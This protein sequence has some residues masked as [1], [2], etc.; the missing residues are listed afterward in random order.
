MGVEFANIGAHNMGGAN[1]TFNNVTFTYASNSLYNGLQHSGN[2]VYNNCTFNGQVFLYGQSETFNNCTFNTTDAANYNVWTYGAKEVAFNNCTFNCAGKSVLIY[3]DQ[4]SVTNNVTVTK[5]QFIASQAVEGKAAIEMDSSISGAVSLTIDGETTAT[6]FAAG[7]VSGNSLWNNKKGNN[8]AKNNDITVVV[9][10]ETVLAPIFEAQIGDVQYRNLQDAINAVQNGETITV[11]RDIATNVVINEKDNV[12]VTIDGN[13]KT[14]NGTITVKALSSDSDRRITIKNINFVNTAD[15]AVDFISSAVTNH[16]PRITVEG[17]TFTGSG[18]ATDVALRLK[19]SKNVEIKNCTGT[20]LH[21]FLQNTSGWNLTIENVK[22]TDSKSGLALGTVQ[23]VT[24]KGCNIDVPGYG[25]RLDAGYN[26]NAVIESNTVEAF[27][28]VVVRNANKDSNIT[29]N[30]TNDMTATNGDNVWCVIGKDEYEE[31]VELEDIEAATGK[32]VVDLSESNLTYEGVY[33]NYA[34]A[35]IGE[36][37][38]ASLQ[39]AIEDAQ[40]GE[41]VILFADTDE[42]V[43][44]NVLNKE[45]S[46]VGEEDLFPVLTGGLDF[47][48]DNHSQDAGNITIKGIKF[49]GNGIK[50]DDMASVTIEGNIFENI[51]ASNAIYVAADEYTT[52]LAITNNIITNVAGAGINLRNPINATVTGNT[53]TNVTGNAMTFQNNGAIE[54]IAGEIVIKGNVLT[55]W[56]YGKTEGRAIRLALGN[57][58]DNVIIEENAMIAA[59]APE[60]FVKISGTSNAEISVDKNYWNG[61]APTAAHFL[62]EGVQIHNYYASYDEANRRLQDLVTIAGETLEIFY[63]AAGVETTKEQAAYSLSFAV[64]DYDNKEASVKIGSKKPTTKDRIEIVTPATVAFEGV[65]YNVTSLANNAFNGVR[66]IEELIISEGVKSLGSKALANMYE[67]VDVVLPSTL[68]SVGDQC[69]YGYGN[70]H[71]IKT[72]TCLAV[73]PPTAS[74]HWQTASFQTWVAEN[75]ILFVAGDAKVYKKAAGW[76]RFTNIVGINSEIEIPGNYYLYTMKVNV[77]SVS[78]RAA[79]IKIGRRFPEG[80]PAILDTIP[81]TASFYG[82][83]Y[84]ITSIPEKGFQGVKFEKIVIPGNI[85]NIGNTAFGGS[86]LADTLIIEEGVETLGNFAF[87]GCYSLS[88]IILP[89]TLQ[90]VG[91]KCFNNVGVASTNQEAVEVSLVYTGVTPPTAGANLFSN[92][93]QGT[94]YVPTLEVVESFKAAAGWNISSIKPFEAK[95]GETVYYS[96]AKAIKASKAGDVITLIADVETAKANPIIIPEGVTLDIN[97]HNITANI[98]GTVE[99]DGGVWTTVAVPGFNSRD[100]LGEGAIYNTTDA[101]V[102]NLANEVN[103]L[104]GTIVLNP[105]PETEWW[106]LPGQSLSIATGATFEIPSGVKFTVR[107]GNA[108]VNGTLINNGTLAIN[109]G[110]TVTGNLTGD[111]HFLGGNFITA[112][113]YKMVGTTSEYFY[114][115]TN[116]LVNIESTFGDITILSGAMTLGQ[117]WRTVQGQTLTVAEGASF[118]VPT[119]MRFD[120]FANTH[121]V[122]EGTLVTDG[123]VYLQA[124]ATV[125]AEADLN[126]QTTVPGHV[127][128]YNNGVYSV[129]EQTIFTQTIQ[130]KAG[131]NWFSSY[132]ETDL[133][134]LQA[135][136]GENGLVIKSDVDGFNEYLEGWG[137]DGTL[138]PLSPSQ[139]YMIE[140]SAP[141]SLVLSGE[142]LKDVEITLYQGWNWISFP[143]NTNISVADA[144]ARLTATDGDVIKSNES[145]FAEYLEGWGWDGTLSLAPG[146]GYMYYSN[147][148]TPVTFTYS[149]SMSKSEAKANITTEGNYW[150]PN[151]AQFANNMTMTAVLDVENINYEVAAFVNGECRGSARPI[152]VEALDAYMLFLTIH[153]EEVEE[154]TFKYYDIDTDTEY[155]LSDRI[156]YS[157]N[158]ILGSLKEPYMFTRGTTGIGEAELSQLNIYPNPT[159]TAAE[160]NLN[161]TF[162][163]V[164]VFNALGVKVAEYSN[165]D[166]IDALETAGIYVIRATNNSV[167]SHCRLVVK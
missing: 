101:T 146:Q 11:L 120:V 24:V 58:A 116:A 151:A 136:L 41:T 99:T 80:V 144:F 166:S 43:S 138:Q 16:Y 164:E 167:I 46:I 45:I 122:V 86:N 142:L 126:I 47:G 119:D 31:G 159:T 72:I 129:V 102:V 13:G 7:N 23:G 132:V 39:A 145:G 118:T 25:I 53:I 158:A 15:A 97:T 29:F 96:L 128:K 74:G 64:T 91:E 18:D 155:T 85:K 107:E 95:I 93:I 104:A 59:N 44:V 33:G 28:P 140:T 63:T 121:V 38:Y 115:A 51:T 148:E 1:V 98:Y 75:V 77:T 35:K 133:E 161:A 87:Q 2:L 137:W 37:Q 92:N 81:E 73:T 60:E 69:F 100:M 160:I 67:L 8:D 57:I 42:V 17:C 106:T 127:V 3:S 135:A 109:A 163:K 70:G 153:G 26:N 103:V 40:N 6:D 12:K 21:S 19:S 157:N 84:P 88:E 78:P 65:K 50:I 71:K 156:N 34:V 108:N 27:I 22:V 114:N 14:M 90:S 117:S 131:W 113:G 83:E 130:L 125:R 94:L 32:V 9:N 124:G 162:D 30:G 147:N 52:T 4:P 49:V 111:I 20:G 149:P 139:M 152:Y 79:S 141:H 5:S 154:M 123:I 82:I 165:V 134:S 68:V 56:A 10:G 76:S 66:G 105:H 61:V 89:S 110:A 36:V 150:T 54:D 112:D 48:I 143:M 55:D 62:A